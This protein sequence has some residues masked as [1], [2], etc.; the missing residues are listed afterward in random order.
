M[1]EQ[2]KKFLLETQKEGFE[3]CIKCIKDMSKATESTDVRNTFE[4][5]IVCLEDIKNS[6]YGDNK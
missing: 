4:A 5:L 1:E 2:L 3:Q 6:I